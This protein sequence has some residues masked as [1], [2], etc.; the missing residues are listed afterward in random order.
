MLSPR[1]SVSKALTVM[2][3]YILELEGQYGIVIR[4]EDKNRLKRD[5]NSCFEVQ[6]C[7]GTVKKTKLPC[8]NGAIKGGFCGLHSKARHQAVHEE[9]ARKNSLPSGP[10]HIDHPFGVRVVGCPACD[11]SHV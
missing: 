10:A 7:K 5:L 4:D 3:D 8:T 11:A 2:E 6:L 9:I 1:K